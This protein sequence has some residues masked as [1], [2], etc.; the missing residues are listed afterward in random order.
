MMRIDTNPDST[1][2]L[3]DYL[4][5]ATMRTIRGSNRRAFCRWGCAGS[6]AERS[7]AAF[8]ALSILCVLVFAAT[9]LGQD[10]KH[11]RPPA[12]QAGKTVDAQ[13]FHG[14]WELVEWSSQSRTGPI[15]PFGKDAKGMLSYDAHG[16]MSV[17]LMRAERPNFQSEDLGLAE[18]AEMESAFR[19]YIAYFGTYSVDQQAET[20]THHLKGCVFPN[21]TGTSQVRHYAFDKGNLILSTP[22]IVEDGVAKTHRLIW[23]PAVRR[24]N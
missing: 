1:N 23:K 18:G 10:A 11:P 9:G 17:H 14:T 13:A 8:L 19:G 12:Q 5:L 16:N 7:H 22:P 6:R 3:E 2:Q 15:F 21:W 4:T 24:D 20:V